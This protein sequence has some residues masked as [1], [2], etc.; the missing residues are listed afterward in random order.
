[1]GLCRQVKKRRRNNGLAIPRL[2]VK[3]EQQ[4]SKLEMWEQPIGWPS[5]L[6]DLLT[7]SIESAK[8][9][10]TCKMVMW[11]LSKLKWE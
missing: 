6:I 8:E 11:Q 3:Q 9:Q 1:M 4:Y 10:E 7:D 5:K 2:E